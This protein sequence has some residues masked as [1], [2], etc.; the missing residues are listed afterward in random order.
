MAEKIIFLLASLSTLQSVN[1]SE[2]AYSAAQEAPAASISTDEDRCMV[3][4][5]PLATP[6][7][8]NQEQTCING[9]TLHKHC[10]I[11]YT[12]SKNDDSPVP[13]PLCSI[14]I[15]NHTIFQYIEADKLE[16]FKEMVKENHFFLKLKDSKN[17]QSILHKAAHFLRPEF[18]KFIFEQN[19]LTEDEVNATDNN[20]NHPLHTALSAIANY[21]PTNKDA[22]KNFLQNEVLPT[23]QALLSSE[24]TK[25]CIQNNWEETPL[26]ATFD[27]FKKED[28]DQTIQRIIIKSFLEKKDSNLLNLPDINQNY[29]ADRA[30]RRNNIELASFL[31]KHGC[32]LNKKSIRKIN[33][34]QKYA[35][36]RNIFIKQFKTFK[37]IPHLP[38]PDDDSYNKNQISP[39][40]LRSIM[41][42]SY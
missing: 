30:L 3:C 14:D 9:H 26:I 11:K 22:R 29:P 20:G 31:I 7:G 34:D 24:K 5:S 41:S 10:L 13:C 35:S 23:M 8:T 19:A 39:T 42:K 27:V 6:I 15:N 2:N 36:I 33:R 17:G 37:P 18:I 21:K 12:A 1:C 28:F 16:P 40:D 25:V 32:P 38:S 4:L